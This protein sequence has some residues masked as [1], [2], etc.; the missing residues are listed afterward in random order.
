LL[1]R[2]NCPLQSCLKWIDQSARKFC[3]IDWAKLLI[4]W[5][6]NVNDEDIKHKSL[7]VT[8]S[9]NVEMKRLSSDV[10][11]DNTFTFTQPK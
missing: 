6:I 9:R 11:C 2:T 8:F 7:R 3:V 5:R 4:E 10:N 1:D